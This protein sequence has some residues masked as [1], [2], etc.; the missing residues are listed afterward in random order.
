MQQKFGLLLDAKVKGANNIRRLG[1]DMQGVQG[2]VKNLGGAVRGLGMAFKA[3]AATAAVAGFAALIKGAADQADAMGKLATRTGIAADKLQGFVN[4]GKLADVSQEQLTSG[5][6]VFAR[7]QA[8][9]AEGVATY[10]DAYAKLGVSVTKSDGSL[11]ASDALLG[12][13]ADRFADLPDGPAKAAVA[14][15]IFGRSG[16]Q[17]ITLLNGGSAALEEFSYELSENFAANA[18]YFN[19]LMTQIGIKF[20]GFRLQLM[21]AVM[22]ALI[23]IAQVFG[24]L[25]ATENDW[26]SLFQVIS[27]GMRGISIVLLSMVKLVDELIRYWG[28][29]GSAIKAVFTGDF[30]GAAEIAKGFGTGFVDRF[31]ENIK[32]FERL[33]YGM[34]E[35]P[36]GY[37][38]RTGGTSLPMTAAT[39]A[40]SRSS[41]AS[42]GST[43]KQMSDQM[44]GLLRQINQAKE[45]GNTFDLNTLE[46]RR[47]ILKI[48]ESSLTGNNKLAALDEARTDLNLRLQ[49]I[50]AANT[51]QT[52]ELNT[53]TEKTSGLFSQIKDTV[54]TGLGNA[55]E[56]LIDGTKT[57][58]ES[59]SGILKQLSSMVLQFGMQSLVGGIFPSA[60]GNVFASNG[61]VPF[62]RGGVVGSPTLFPFAKGVGLMGEA[63]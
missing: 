11:K 56:G 21:D 36:G 25:F 13:I 9:A 16:A 19:D 59:L 29:L 41:A 60:K 6:R 31:Q 51:E 58:G 54:A 38:L 61:I 27:V 20:E 17:M 52:K 62:A 47:D 1:N 26:S 46:Y 32:Q 37:Q 44:L 22:P 12:E 30:A 5:L 2:K 40:G 49:D 53:E 24:E 57:L 50:Y 18:Q 15:D 10:A 34:G 3:L 4:A 63:G 43:T 45:R 23:E 39:A 28:A 33:A 8:E 55:I 7:T 14:M 35:A 42:R 48:E